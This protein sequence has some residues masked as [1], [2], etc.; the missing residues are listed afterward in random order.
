MKL[1][2]LLSKRGSGQPMVQVEATV[3]GIKCRS[4]VHKSMRDH[5]LAKWL[6]LYYRGYVER[7]NTGI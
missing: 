5:G 1:S 4:T 3:R 7:A 2:F 6:S